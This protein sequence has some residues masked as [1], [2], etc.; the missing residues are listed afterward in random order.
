MEFTVQEGSQFAGLP[1]R[2]MGLPSGCILI[3]CSDGRREWIPQANTRLEA[4]MRITAVIAPEAS[5]GI[6]TLRLGC[7]APKKKRGR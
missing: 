6:D 4:H 5:Q 7:E 1:V 3:R 2:E